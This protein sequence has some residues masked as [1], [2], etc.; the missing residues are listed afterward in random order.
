MEQGSWHLVE[1][2]LTTRMA[3][4]WIDRRFVA[5]AA[6]GVA[7][8]GFRRT[9]PGKFGMVSYI[10]PYLWRNLVVL[11]PEVHGLRRHVFG[12]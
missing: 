6:L 10:T 3:A 4:Y 5:G 12:D 2:H 8:E 9:A 7:A 1:V 11:R